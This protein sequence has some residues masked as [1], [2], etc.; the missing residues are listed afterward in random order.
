MAEQPPR[1]SAPSSPFGQIQ[2]RP[3]VLA[4]VRKSLGTDTHNDGVG[5]LV[6]DLQSGGLYRSASAATTGASYALTIAWPHSTR[7]PVSVLDRGQS[8]NPVIL[9]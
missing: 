6:S 7:R 1:P 2:S 8:P 3:H 5:R 4:T 9:L